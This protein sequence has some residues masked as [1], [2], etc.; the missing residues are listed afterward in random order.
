MGHGLPQDAGNAG[1]EAGR[2]EGAFVTGLLCARSRT[3]VFRGLGAVREAV[4]SLAPFPGDGE[5]VGV[6]AVFSQHLWEESSPGIDKPVTHLKKTS[7]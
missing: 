5:L 3:A 4:T 6:F 7:T 1:V 2:V